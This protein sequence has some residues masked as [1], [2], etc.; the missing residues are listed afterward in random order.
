APEGHAVFFTA[1]IE[2]PELV[3]ALRGETAWQLEATVPIGTYAGTPSADV[4]GPRRVLVRMRPGDTS[5]QEYEDQNGRWVAI[6][7]PLAVGDDP[8]TP[9]D[10]H[11]PNLTPNGLTMVYPGF[12]RDGDPG[13]FAQ[14]RASVDEPFGEPVVLRMGPLRRPQLC[15]QCQQLYAIDSLG[16]APTVMRFDR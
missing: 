13:I 12:D 1:P 9:D 16:E 8:L 15:G 5:V 6:G 7:E 3:G 4:F 10:V 11:A 14:S 2:P